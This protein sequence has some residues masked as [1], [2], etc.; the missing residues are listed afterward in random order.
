MKKS[1]VLLVTLVLGFGQIF[2]SDNN[3]I[4]SEQQIRNEVAILL[5]SPEITVEKSNL[6][7]DIQ[8][9]LNKNG[10]IEVLTVD[11]NKNNV[12]DYVKSRLNNKKVLEQ[13]I[14]NVNRVYNLTL[15]IKKPENI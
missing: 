4:E 9:K 12:I 13:K 8:F 2:A 7:A 5:K 10:E 1:I 11:S 3:L 6:S 15:I 14:I